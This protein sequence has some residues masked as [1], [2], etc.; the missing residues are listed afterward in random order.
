VSVEAPSY[1]VFGYRRDD[2]DSTDDVR[3]QVPE[4]NLV[5]AIKWALDRGCDSI[6]VEL[7]GT[8]RG[9]PGITHHLCNDPK[10]PGGCE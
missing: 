9:I 10:C 3:R 7:T 5:R 6:L 1:S 2:E 4:W 8:V